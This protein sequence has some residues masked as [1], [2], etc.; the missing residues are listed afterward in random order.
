VTPL[1]GETLQEIPTMNAIVSQ[2][3]PPT[4]STPSSK[5]RRW[6]AGILAGVPV[7]FLVFDAAMKLVGSPFVAEAMTRMGFPEATARPIGLI[8]LACVVL[9]VVPRTAV[10]GAILLTGYLGGA[11]CAHVRLLDPLLSHV[12]FPIYVAAMLWGSLYLRDGR[13]RAIAPWLNSRAG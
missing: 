1:L 7:L 5:K 3:V 13:V 4:V 10:L 12:L 8:L 2:A 9:Y 11:I 6:A